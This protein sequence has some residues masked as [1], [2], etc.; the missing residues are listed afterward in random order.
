MNGLVSGHLADPGSQ[1]WRGPRLP[2]GH[3]LLCWRTLADCVISMYSR[4]FFCVFTTRNREMMLPDRLRKALVY[5][6]GVPSPIGWFWFS[7]GV[8]L[9]ERVLVH[10]RPSVSLWAGPPPWCSHPCA[11]VATARPPLPAVVLGAVI[12]S[13]V[14]GGLLQ[15]LW[16][17]RDA[18]G[19][20][21][22][23][24]CWQ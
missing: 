8:G 16:G 15:R 10:R 7:C 19:L 23:T 13:L 21:T 11:T 20:G 4:P 5:L 12:V 2:R 18:P 9:R 14:W 17:N 3:L 6:E 1:A 22:W 24:V